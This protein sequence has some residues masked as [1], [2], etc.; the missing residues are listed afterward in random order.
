M[1]LIKVQKWQLENSISHTGD[2]LL[3]QTLQ[4]KSLI[5]KVH[6]SVRLHKFFFFFLT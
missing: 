1:E 3:Q 4:R 5:K 2:Q 6:L